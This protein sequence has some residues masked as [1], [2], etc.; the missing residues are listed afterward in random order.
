MQTHT[1]QV[2]GGSIVALGAL[3]AAL[4]A[5]AAG[6][7]A[8]VTADLEHG[9][10]YVAGELLLQFQAG[11]SAAEQDSA[12]RAVGA[13]R[14]E[15]LLAAGP[16]ADRGGELQ[17]LRLPLPVDLVRALRTLETQPAVDF[18]EPN[19][20]YQHSLAADD[21][22]YTSG[23]LWGMSPVYGSQA[24][25]AWGAGHVCGP[26]VV[27]GIIDEGVMVKH[28]DLAANAWVNP[29][30]PVDGLDND[31]NGYVDDVNGWDFD[32]GNNS[33]FDGSQDDH[34]THVAGTI[35]A[36]GGNSK[37][38]AGLCWRATL[39]STKFL[40]RRGG[41]TANAIRALDY[42][43]DLKRRHG[44][45]LVAT[46]NSWGGG[47]Y[48]QALKDAIERAN[49]AGILFVAAAGN[50]SRDNDASPGYPASYDNSN[51]IA[52]A[53]LTASGALASYSNYGAA[54]VDLGAPGSAIYSTLPK[55]S[56]GSIV[57]GYGAYSGT[58]MATPHVTG[59]ALLYASTHPGA[60]PLQIRE[61][62]LSS[63][64]PTAALAGKC[65]TGGRLN[66]STY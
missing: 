20:L 7:P 10:A 48:S 63:T 39:I 21:P 1:R 8:A 29:Y 11:A 28:E 2:L 58:S 3:V 19:W 65:V 47:G 32:G 27:V 12:L 64:T 43:S 36:V 33:I 40:G 30:D 55:S 14:V 26:E 62:L 4:P 51:V 13:E 18:A 9:R 66:V 59:A 54:S 23:Q 41:T 44:L 22:Y 24:D 53:A 34:G 25:L 38:V 61:A 56:K 17:R 45:N 57:S 37:G 52:V 42:L 49:T 16:R 60:T 6:Q 5:L 50:E 46:N 31:G 15:Q 35:A